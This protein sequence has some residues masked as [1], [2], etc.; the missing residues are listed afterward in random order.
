MNYLAHGYRFLDDPLFLAGTAVPDWLSVSDRQTRMRTRR[1]RER[2]NELKP[3][4]QR[5]ADGIAQ[6]LSDDDVFHR[7]P[8]FAMLEAEI[9]SRF[10]AHMPDR[11]DH[12]PGFLG[13]ILTEMLLDA[14]I[15]ENDPAVLRRYYAA[16]LDVDGVFVEG[17]VNQLAARMASRLAEFIDRF[18][19]IE[20][21]Y[22]YLDN[23]KLLSR[24]NQVLRRVT[25]PP[26]DD[27]F[28][29]VLG[30]ARQLLRVH[31]DSLLQ[32]VVSA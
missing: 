32:G 25:L 3:T 24:L 22:D 1:I 26:L 27:S 11:F 28:E 19:A 18:V 31:G 23:A 21:L 17:T 2:R 16:L 7:L 10:R 4:Q 14:F 9:A 30:D 29:S 8:E 5:I 6:H 20:F 12:L 13:H 15:T